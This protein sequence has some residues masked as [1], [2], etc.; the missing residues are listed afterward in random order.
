MSKIVNFKEFLTPKHETTGPKKSQV[1][2]S[3]HY[4]Y[5]YHNGIRTNKHTALK[6]DLEPPFVSKIMT[7]TAFSD[8]KGET[9][10]PLKT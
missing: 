1:G 7:F 10:G 6:N 3:Y 9:E 5:Q 4:W 8:P 2:S